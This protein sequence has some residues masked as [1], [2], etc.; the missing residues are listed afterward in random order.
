[1]SATRSRNRGTYASRCSPVIT[2]NFAI[3]LFVL[4]R[5]IPLNSSSGRLLCVNVEFTLISSTRD[6]ASTLT[7][8]ASI[9][10]PITTHDDQSQ[11]VV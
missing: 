8:F 4:L 11:F 9:R 10:A 5:V 6:S 1:M 2:V 3:Y 7:A